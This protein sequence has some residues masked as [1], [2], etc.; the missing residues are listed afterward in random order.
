MILPCL[1]LAVALLLSA[2]AY[3]CV[4]GDLVVDALGLILKLLGK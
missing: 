3:F 1:I 4:D 2:I